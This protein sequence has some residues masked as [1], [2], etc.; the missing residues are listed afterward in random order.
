MKQFPEQVHIK[1]CPE[2]RGVRGRNVYQLTTR[3][4]LVTGAGN[5]LDI[6]IQQR[7][8]NATSP[9]RVRADLAS[10]HPTPSGDYELLIPASGTSPAE[11]VQ[12]QLFRVYRTF[13]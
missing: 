10:L 7:F 2:E 3:R 9:Y 4:Q 1:A 5:S 13:S 11:R 12:K 6:V 8:V